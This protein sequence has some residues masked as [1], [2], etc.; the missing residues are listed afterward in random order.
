MEPPWA[1][2]TTLKV[3]ETRAAGVCSPESW[4]EERPTE[5]DSGRSQGTSHFFLV[6]HWQEYADEETHRGQV[7]N[8][9]DGV[10]GAHTGPVIVVFPLA[11]EGETLG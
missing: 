2:E 10:L 8:H 6:G 3:Q 1:E 9:L 5:Q 11:R 7:K 4:R